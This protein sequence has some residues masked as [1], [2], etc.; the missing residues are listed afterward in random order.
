[1]SFTQ[2]AWLNPEFYTPLHI[3]HCCPLCSVL[4]R[5]LWPRSENAPWRT[6][7]SSCHHHR[8]CW[9]RTEAFGAVMF[10]LITG[11]G[12]DLKKYIYKLCKTWENPP[13]NKCYSC[14][15]WQFKD[16]FDIFFGYISVDYLVT[17]LYSVSYFT[18]YSYTSYGGSCP[19]FKCSSPDE[20]ETVK[21]QKWS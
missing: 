20:T 18:L 10:S 1:M 9:T 14:D 11:H 17:C 8:L 5:P 3:T 7:I 19:A 6:L 12:S 21:L 2:R 4:C 15:L 16:Q 13:E